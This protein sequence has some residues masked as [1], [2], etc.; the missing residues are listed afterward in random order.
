VTGPAYGSRVDT[1]RPPL[2][3]QRL[4]DGLFV[5]IHR[6]VDLALKVAL[7]IEFDVPQAAIATGLDVPLPEVKLAI[8]RLRRIATSID[9]ERPAE[10]E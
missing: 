5:D 1:G 6:D 3:L 7:L 10:H 4:R 2:D 8:R 9:W